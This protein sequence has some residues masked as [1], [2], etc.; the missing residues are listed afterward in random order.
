MLN[1]AQLKDYERDGFL[2]LRSH[3]TDDEMARLDRAFENN[4]PLNGNT[5]TLNYPEPG[6]YTLAKSCLKDPDLAFIAEHP[7]IVE[8]TKELLQDDIHLTAFVLY[9]RTPGGAGM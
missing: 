9:D 6:R 8:P 4:P 2:V 3:F 7:G 5:G 1:E